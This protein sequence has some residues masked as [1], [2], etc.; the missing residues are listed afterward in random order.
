LKDTNKKL[1]VSQGLPDWKAYVDF[2]NNVVVYGLIDAMASTLRTMAA[3]FN[4]AYL[5]LNALPPLLEIQLDLRDKKVAFTPEVGLV[6]HDSSIHHT[7]HT[8]TQ[9]THQHEAESG[10]KNIVSGWINGILG[11]SSAF[12]RL[13]SGEGT[14][15]RE[16]SESPEVCCQKAKVMRFLS[17]MEANANR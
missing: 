1:K 5:E 2:T 11:L 13:D 17:H 3:Q 8:H 15:L 14:Y 16:I 12:K 7:H 6:E 10:I 9:H 4:P